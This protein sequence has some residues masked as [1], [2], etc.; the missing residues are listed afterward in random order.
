MESLVITKKGQELITKMI[1]GEDTATFTKLVTTDTDCSSLVLEDLE[2]LEAKQE[3][4]VSAVTVTDTNLVEVIARIDNSTLSDGYYVKTAGLYAKNSS[5]T[6]I[7][8]AVS[9]AG[10][11]ADYMPAFGGKTVTGITYRLNVKVDNSSA[12]EIVIDPAAVP[13][14]EQVEKIN[15]EIVEIGKK[16]ESEDELIQV[17]RKTI[18]STD[19]SGIDD[20][21]LTGIVKSFYGFMKHIQDGAAAHNGIYVCEDIT[22][23]WNDGTFSK[24]V[25]N[26]T[27]KDIFP[28]MYITKSYTASGIETVTEDFVVA[29]LDYHLHHGDTETTAHHALMLMKNGASKTQQMNSSNVTTGGYTG[30]NMWKSIIPKYASAMQ[31]AFG[32]GHIL[33]HRELLTTAISTSGTSMAGA[34]LTGYAS[35]WAWTDVLFNIMN[36]AMCFGVTATSSSFYDTGDC[37][38][39]L[40]LLN[41][42]GGSKIAHL[43]K[44][45]GRYWYWLRDVAS[46]APFADCGYNGDS[47][48]A[49]ASD[50]YA[51]R[52]YFLL[53]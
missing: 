52:G 53:R 48:Y 50:S 46:S 15:E 18:G 16:I 1:A 51:L 8:Y 11:V 3:A 13:S 31:N 39:Q 28:G 42:D 9:I 32:S 2:T 30:S 25:Q 6:E 33:S 19:I 37:T 5:G 47:G 20:G 7:L 36:N 21:T 44:G 24:N 17:V 14:M 41:L 22:D 23:M 29:D 38:K 35:G 40:S 4:L 10:D 12:V 26:G 43:G 27:F 49:G 45:G 34:G